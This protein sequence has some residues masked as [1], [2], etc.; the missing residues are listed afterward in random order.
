MSKKCKR[1]YKELSDDAKYC[2]SCG[3]KTRWLKDR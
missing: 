2:D 3:K 1:C